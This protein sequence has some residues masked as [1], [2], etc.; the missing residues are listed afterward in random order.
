MSFRP[1]PQLSTPPGFLWGAATAAHQVEGNNVASDWW[2]L[3]HSGSPVIT[4]PSGDAA[5]HFSRWPEDLDI[6][7]GLGLNA[8]R[9]SLEWSRIE[10]EP[11][12][13]SA[14]ALD[15]YRRMVAGCVER[16]LSPVVT[17]QHVTMPA[18]F[19]R[20]GGWQSDGAAERFAGFAETVLPVLNE[21]AEWVATI[22]EPSLQPLMSA[23]HRGDPAA[24]N[25]WHGGPMPLATPEEVD[26][27]VTA[28]RAARD[29]VR[30]G[31]Q[32][33]AG[34]TVVV[35][36]MQYGPEGEVHAKEWFEANE[37]PYLRA[38]AGDDFIG[39]QN[40]TRSRFDADGEVLPGPDD[41][42]TGIWEYYPEALGNAVRFTRS[43]V[44]DVPILITENGLPTN[45]DAER[46]EFID[47]ALRS[48][49][50]AI[51]DGADV[52]GYI[53][54]SAIDNFEWALGYAPRFGLISVDP[55]TFERTVKPSAR[56]YGELARRQSF[57]GV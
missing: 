1:L 18:W 33:K 15:H 25:A 7:A 56:W 57:A 22:N 10:P 49:D 24:L 21:G 26:A 39:V 5:D 19:R 13:I 11:G 4:E 43:V 17:L 53:H 8:Y 51:A 34:W 47:R 31:T 29:V 40:Y 6:L 9:F 38:S 20:A 55:R 2:G 42:M 36:D 16:G 14:A 48:L 44:G 23:L 52:R 32:A 27:L 28:H 35:H 30:S 54:W 12:A 41:R 37:A 45:D 3:E 50:G 46:V